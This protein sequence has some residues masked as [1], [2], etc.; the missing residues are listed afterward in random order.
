MIYVSTKVWTFLDDWIS[1]RRMY[2]SPHWIPKK[3]RIRICVGLTAASIYILCG[4]SMGLVAVSND[5]NL[6]GH[7]ALVP[8]SRGQKNTDVPI[9]YKIII[10]VALLYA[11]SASMLSLLLYSILC[12]GLSLEFRSLTS[13]IKGKVATNQSFEGDLEQFRIQH[14]QI[15]NLVSKMD[16]IFSCYILCCFLTI[17]PVLCFL[18]YGL[19]HLKQVP[20]IDIV[21]VTGLLSCLVL[22]LMVIILFGT[23]L[24]S[25]VRPMLLCLSR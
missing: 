18:L 13:I 9:P 8:W 4:I 6:F 7:V 23:M 3:I 11:Y 15:C 2:C 24:A 25:A 22:I 14:G 16:N 10:A 17:I 5:N 20:V 1:Y 19:F 12:Y 21:Y